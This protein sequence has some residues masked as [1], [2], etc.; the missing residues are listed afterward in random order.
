MNNGE[1]IT[2]EKLLD[3]F[4]PIYQNINTVKNNQVK[5]LTT[6]QVLLNAHSTQDYVIESISTTAPQ[7]FQY[8][9]LTINPTYIYFGTK[10]FDMSY[11]YNLLNSLEDDIMQIEKMRS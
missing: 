8:S 10:N 7:Y 4:L 1:Q 9:S 3:L 2:S 11:K 6:G 5:A